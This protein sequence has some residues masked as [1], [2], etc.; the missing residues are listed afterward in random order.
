M[1]AKKKVAPEA[2]KPK[3]LDGALYDETSAFARLASKVGEL[4]PAALLNSLATCRDALRR[5]DVDY[6]ERMEKATA[7]I[8]E[9]LRNEL[10]SIDADRKGLKTAM[11]KAE[12]VFAAR[13][14]EIKEAGGDLPS[15]TD[16][17]VKLTIVQMHSLGLK[18]GLA[19]TYDGDIAD[20]HFLILQTI[21]G[22][23]MPIPM[24]YIKPPSECI[25]WKAVEADKAKNELL[26]QA[27]EPEKYPLDFVKD[28]VKLSLRTK[29]PDMEE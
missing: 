5:L 2:E 26:V 6:K 17:G 10:A 20:S 9:A 28:N 23:R 27:G 12:K 4:V 13:M 1:A 11:E 3:Y 8:P 14:V 21:N 7:K 25:D 29:L 19:W 16:D 22:E 18:D 24:K 15:E